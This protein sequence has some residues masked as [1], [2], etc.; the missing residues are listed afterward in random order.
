MLILAERDGRLKLR[1]FRESDFDAYLAMRR[2]AAF[3]RHYEPEQMSAAFSARLLEGFLVQR[4]QTP[5]VDWQL[6]IERCGDGALIGSVGLRS[7]GGGEAEFGIELAETAWR[8]GYAEE[9]AR[10]MLAFGRERLAC[11][12]FHAHCAPG[13]VAMLLLA[14][15]LGFGMQPLRDGRRLD[16]LLSA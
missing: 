7:A 1:D 5:R 6:A 9:A 12:R 14:Q 4:R 16:L 8:Q 10:L 3:G 2:G 15:R 11:R 13:N